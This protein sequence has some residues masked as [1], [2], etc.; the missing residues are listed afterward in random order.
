M[1]VD[2]ARI[3]FLDGFIA[4][5]SGDARPHVLDDDVGLFRKPHQD[6]TAFFVLQVQRD[7][8]LLR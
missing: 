1:F 8:A 3:A 2:D 6:F 5:A 4:E 7:G